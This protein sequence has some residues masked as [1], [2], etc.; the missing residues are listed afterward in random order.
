MPKYYLSKAQILSRL[1]IALRARSPDAIPPGII[2]SVSEAIQEKD[3]ATKCAMTGSCISCRSHVIAESEACPRSMDCFV[4]KHRIIRV[5]TGVTSGSNLRAG[6]LCATAPYRKSDLAMTEKRFF[7]LRS[8]ND[9]L[10][11]CVVLSSA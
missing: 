4:A 10:L 8:Q 11:R 3:R 1:T 5:V 7:G 2:A 9:N 6:A